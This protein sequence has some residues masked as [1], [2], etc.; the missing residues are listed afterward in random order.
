MDLTAKMIPV[1]V[2]TVEKFTAMGASPEHIVRFLQAP[3]DQINSA[4]A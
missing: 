2:E 3:I 4:K 1:M